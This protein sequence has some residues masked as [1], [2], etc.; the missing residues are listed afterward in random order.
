MQLVID[1]V[2]RDFVPLAAYRAAHGLPDDFSLA[3]FHPKDFTGLGRIDSAEAGAQ[4]NAL[5]AS[6]LERTPAGLHPSDW[7]TLLPGLADA[8]RMTLN[9]I[10]PV[11]GLHDEEIDFAAAG[12][13]DVLHA[14]AYASL[15]A[16]AYADFRAVYSEWLMNSVT[17]APAL[18][19]YPHAGDT[20]HV[21]LVYTA[22]GRAGLVV[23]RPGAGEADYVQDGALGC[24]AEG[25]M[26]GL[27][28]DVYARLCG[29]S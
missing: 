8:F 28:R 25:Y 11:V 21:Q 26:L 20:W 9:T 6:I 29:S 15:R 18:A 27:L 14:L 4:L 17:I 16:G 24:P 1:G 7:L 22:Y 23:M 10:N 19:P 12:F 5:R 3:L 2:A 13:S